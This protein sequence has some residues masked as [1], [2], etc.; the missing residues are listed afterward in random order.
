MRCV[1]VSVILYV[2]RAVSCVEREDTIHACLFLEH[3]E[4][5]CPC[6]GYAMS[7]C[8]YEDLNIV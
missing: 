5:P 7:W 8:D 4:C 1:F 3:L 6:V 2:T